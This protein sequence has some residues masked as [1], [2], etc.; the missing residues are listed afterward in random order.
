MET[1]KHNQITQHQYDHLIREGWSVIS[2]ESYDIDETRYYNVFVE[3]K[4]PTY[5]E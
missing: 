4:L 3:R 5:T 1:A 2:E